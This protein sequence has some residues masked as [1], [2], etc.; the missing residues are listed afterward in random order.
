MAFE[1]FNDKNNSNV[2]KVVQNLHVNPLTATVKKIITINNN[3]ND[4]RVCR[5]SYHKIVI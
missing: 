1:V 2:H 3:S 5:L 4:S